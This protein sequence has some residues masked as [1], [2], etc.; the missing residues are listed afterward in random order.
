MGKIKGKKV[1]NPAKYRKEEYPSVK[2]K[3]RV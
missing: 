3:K 2:C 1:Q